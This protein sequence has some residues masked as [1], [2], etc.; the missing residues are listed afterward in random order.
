MVEFGR[1]GGCFGVL[2]GSTFGEKARSWLVC[3]GVRC[4]ERF[5]GFGIGSVVFFIEFLVV[6]INFTVCRFK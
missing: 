2:C 4:V 6:R 5:G 3:R 1:I